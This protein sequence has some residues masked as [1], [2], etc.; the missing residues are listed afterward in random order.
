MLIIDE[1]VAIIHMQKCGGTT[2]CKGLIGALPAGRLKAYGYNAEGN[3]RARQ[4]RP[5]N[6]LWK[7]ATASDLRRAVGDEKFADLD[8]YCVSSRDPWSR[9]GSYYHYAKR[10]NQNSPDKYKEFSEMSFDDF[11][12]ANNFPSETLMDFTHDRDTGEQL[13]SEVFD[14]NDL[15]GQTCALAKKYGWPEPKMKRHNANPETVDYMAMYTAQTSQHVAD[16][17]AQEIAWLDH[18]IPAFSA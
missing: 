11:V 15:D 16:Y 5:I 18:K 7:H 17:F 14:F 2:V 13:V 3:A 6:G 10:H 9:T 1:R 4:S 8:V 12:L